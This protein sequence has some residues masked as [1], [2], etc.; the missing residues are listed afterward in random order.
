MNLF[1]ILV[2]FASAVL[3][4][5]VCTAV[6]AVWA[7]IREPWTPLAA[8][9]LMDALY[10]TPAV[11]RA[12]LGVISGGVATLVLFWVRSRLRSGIMD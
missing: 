8:G 12:P 3:L 5:W 2:T 4:P 10:Y 7:G 1:R 9:I 6:F 11:S